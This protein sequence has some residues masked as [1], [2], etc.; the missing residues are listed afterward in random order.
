MKSTWPTRKFRIGDRMQPIFHWLGLGFCFGD[1]ANFMFCVGGNANH[2][3][4]GYQHVG[5]PK[6]KLWRWGS[7][8]TPGPNAKGFGS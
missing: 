5:I 7:K 2:G 3:V 6:A 4:F 1:N 8:P